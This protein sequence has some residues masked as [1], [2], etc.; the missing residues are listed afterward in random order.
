[1]EAEYSKPAPDR[2]ELMNAEG[3]ET[4][5][6]MRPHLY[7]VYAEVFYFPAEPE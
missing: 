7:L 3:D 6:S 2:A 5:V 4:G 1:M